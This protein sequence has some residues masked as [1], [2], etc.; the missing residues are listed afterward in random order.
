MR[1][2]AAA[3]TAANGPA[4]FTSTAGASTAFVLL[5]GGHGLSSTGK[6][7]EYA[8]VDAT[9]GLGAFASTTGYANERDGSQ[10]SII[11]G[12]AY[13]FLGGT[14]GMYRKTSDLSTS[15]TLTST[16]LTFGNWSSAGSDVGGNIG[17][18]GLAQ[19]S[20]YFYAIG[21]TADDSNALST[22]WQIIY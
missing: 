16:T 21:G 10:M 11:N 20:A 7:I 18:F 5:S 17:R 15:A 3:M 6:T 14:V 13:G 12:Y 9:G 8:V 2:G 1:M 19:E 4:S 22:V